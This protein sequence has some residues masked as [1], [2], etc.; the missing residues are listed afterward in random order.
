MI[1]VI[2]S[3][4]TSR[5]LDIYLFLLIGLIVAV[6][7]TFVAQRKG[8]PIF[9]EYIVQYDIIAIVTSVIVVYLISLITVATFE[10]DARSIEIRKKSVSDYLTSKN[11]FLRDD[12][13][14]ISA[15][16]RPPFD[17]SFVLTNQR[18]FYY[19]FNHII[20][21]VYFENVI[22]VTCKAHPGYLFCYH[23]KNGSTVTFELKGYFCFFADHLLNELKK[24]M[25]DK[26]EQ[27]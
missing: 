27:K 7:D 16:A 5:F 13:K 4:L 18:M 26:I 11:I 12:E 21:K 8:I 15:S 24:I 17:Q 9:Y 6:L 22:K 3:F 1:K 20:K 2:K 14:I 10:S 19:E 23:L 25:S